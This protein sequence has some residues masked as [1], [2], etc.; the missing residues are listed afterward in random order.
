MEL[1]KQIKSRANSI[2]LLVA[3]NLRKRRIELG[4]TPKS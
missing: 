2:D 4:V 1:L 3:Q